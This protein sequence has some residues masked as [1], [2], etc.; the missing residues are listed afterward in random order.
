MPRAKTM[1]AAD[2][3]A[4][5]LFRLGHLTRVIPQALVHAILTA[6]QKQNAY[7]C[8]LPA[9]LMVYFV[10]TLGLQRREASREVLR[11]ML[12]GLRL[13]WGAARVPAKVACKGAIAMARERLGWEVLR[14]VL[15]QGAQPLATPATRGAWYQG[16][17]LEVIDGTVLA[18]PDTPDNARAFGKSGGKHGPSAFPLVRVVARIE[19]GTHAILDATVGR[20]ADSETGL[21]RPLLATLTRGTLLLVDRLYFSRQRWCDAAATGADLLWRVSAGVAL[22]CEEVLPDGS[23]LTTVYPTDAD[24]RHRRHGVR[25]RVIEYALPGVPGADPCYRVVTTLLDPGT[26]PAATLAAL[27]HERWEGEGVLDELKTHVRGGDAVLLR[28]QTEVTVR[29]EVYGLLLAQYTVRAVMHDAALQAGEDPDRLSFIHTV[30]VLRRA[31]PQG[32][33]LPPSAVVALV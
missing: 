21:A 11:G 7:R 22:P 9:L 33:A 18:V 1:P 10:I 31:V 8:K 14:D 6:H 4:M 29:Q 27:Y 16:R 30:R 15:A 28:S 5:E 19:V 17:R 3:P 25:A 20:Y 2:S 24:R 12:Q 23:Y 32:A 26:D 13:R